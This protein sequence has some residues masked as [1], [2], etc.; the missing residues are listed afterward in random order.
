MW[1][2]FQIKTRNVY[3]ECKL[4]DVDFKYHFFFELLLASRA[5]SL[6]LYCMV[7]VVWPRVPVD[8][9]FTVSISDLCTVFKHWL[10]SGIR[11]VKSM[12]TSVT[13]LSLFL[14]KYGQLV[15]WKEAEEAVSAPQARKHHNPTSLYKHSAY[16]CK[17]MMPS[18]R[19]DVRKRKY[20]ILIMTLSSL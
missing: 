4:F 13:L 11:T 20:A 12:F 19:L 16:F 6:F 10:F 17:R 7:L 2:T 9:M 15:R 5:C 14:S 3:W 8:E 1:W 18:A